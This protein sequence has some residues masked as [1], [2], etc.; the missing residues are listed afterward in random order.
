[1][2]FSKPVISGYVVDREFECIA[3]SFFAEKKFVIG[4]RAILAF[5]THCWSAF[6]S[7]GVEG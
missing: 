7:T 2:P 4:K 6:A 3:T 5:E 1:M